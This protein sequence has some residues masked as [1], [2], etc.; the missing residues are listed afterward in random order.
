MS[1]WSVKPAAV[2]VAALLLVVLAASACSEKKVVVDPNDGLEGVA[3]ESQLIVWRENPNPIFVFTD[4]GTEGP[5]W[6]E[7]Q[8]QFTFEDELV[9]ERTAYET[10]AGTVHGFIFDYTRAG[11]FEVL[12]QEGG[13]FRS[14]KDYL[15]TP[16]RRFPGF[17]TDLFLF[18]DPKPIPGPAPEYVGRGAVD[19]VIAPLSPKTNIGAVTQDVVEPGI[20]VLTPTGLDPRDPP[21]ADSIFVLEWSP[22]PE[23]AG[24][25]LHIYNYTTQNAAQKVLSGVPAPFY[26]GRTRDHILAFFPA[27]SSGPRARVIS[28]KT[29]YPFLVGQNFL[30][31]ISAVNASGQ[32]IAYTSKARSDLVAELANPSSWV[33]NRDNYIVNFPAGTSGTYEVSPLGVVAFQFWGRYGASIRPPNSAPVVI[34]ATAASH[35]TRREGHGSP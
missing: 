5:S 26:F 12:R 10:S 14:F 31:R 1:G 3:S 6:L 33:S 22:Y 16:A 7:N 21:P 18:L 25:W 24:Y 8:Q 11:Q 28:F 15:L 2:R 30:V 23:A 13:G 17:D 32:L 34:G 9:G 19:G 29:Q 20:E 27:T 35:S 4:R